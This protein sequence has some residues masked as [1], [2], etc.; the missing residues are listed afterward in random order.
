M[1]PYPTLVQSAVASRGLCVLP[2]GTNPTVVPLAS[3]DSTPEEFEA[4]RPAEEDRQQLVAVSR[5]GQ[6]GRWMVG[7]RSCEPLTDL[8]CATECCSLMGGRQ[9]VVGDRSGRVH[10]V[11][12]VSGRPAPGLTP[13]WQVSRGAITALHPHP[14]RRGM[15]AAATS[16]GDCAVR[17]LDVLHRKQLRVLRGHEGRVTDVDWVNA[18][19]AQASLL[20]SVGADA[21]LRLWSGQGSEN[22]ACAATLLG[23]DAGVRCVR[24]TPTP[25]SPSVLCSGGDDGAV[26]V[27]DATDPR[28]ARPTATLHGHTGPVTD[29]TPLCGAGVESCVASASFDRTVRVW[30][31]RVND[32]VATLSDHGGF[33]HQVTALDERAA[34]GPRIATAANDG[35]IK[36]WDLRNVVA[37]AAKRQELE[38]KFASMNT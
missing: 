3:I 4:R 17:I 7:R 36:V 1:T 15:V 22:E 25:G 24:H 10:L 38:T 35:T 18:G 28:L 11:D 32:Y 9:L 2:V 34:G 19:G 30:D 8:R 16:S 13:S 33:V 6:L 21:T 26:V 5:R 29:V 27:W 12:A 14:A 37:A 31:L 20:A 23:H